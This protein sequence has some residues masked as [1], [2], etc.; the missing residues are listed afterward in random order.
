M[1]TAPTANRKLAEARILAARLMP[2]MRHSIMALLPTQDWIATTELPGR[3]KA[4]LAMHSITIPEG[5]APQAV[6]DLA[7]MPLAP[8]ADTAEGEGADPDLIAR[9]RKW[10][11]AADRGPAV[12]G[13]Q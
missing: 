13:P 5:L 9:W 4:L 8:V 6:T 2:Y 3:V 1:T 7:D 11:G 10:V 12:S